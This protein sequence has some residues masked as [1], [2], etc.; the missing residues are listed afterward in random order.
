LTTKGLS[1][2]IAIKASMNLGLSDKLSQHF[3][4]ISLIDRPIV[5]SQKIQ[6][7]NWLSG[8]TDGEGCFFC[9]FS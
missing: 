4:D 8:F 5:E 9:L 1:E 2:I 7:P 3:P 6:D